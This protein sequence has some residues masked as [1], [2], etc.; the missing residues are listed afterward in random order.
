MSGFSDDCAMLAADLF[1][2][3][4][5]AAQDP[6]IIQRRVRGAYSPAEQIHDPDT[7]VNYVLTR[8]IL[9]RSD[10]SFGIASASSR[11]MEEFYV[12]I[13]TADL[14]LA[15]WPGAATE[16]LDELAEIE[17]G[18]ERWFI[19]GHARHCC[20][21]VIRLTCRLDTGVRR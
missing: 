8:Y 20:G 3:G 4:G 2:L 7:V 5:I 9:S 13:M 10:Q 14:V 21:T 6:I 19:T 1:A 12:E 18:S 15:G 11:K 17:Y 16:P